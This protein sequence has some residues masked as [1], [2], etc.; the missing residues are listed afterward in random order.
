MTAKEKLLK[1]APGWSE[2]TAVAVL[3]VVESQAKLERWLEDETPEDVEARAQRGAEASLGVLQRMD[4]EEE[5]A[6][7][8]WEEFRPK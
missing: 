3:R 6:G 8:G 2:A 7:L 4:E 5:A 1:D